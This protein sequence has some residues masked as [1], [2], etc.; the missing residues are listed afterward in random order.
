MLVSAHNELNAHVKQLGNIKFPSPIL[1]N[2]VLVYQDKT[3]QYVIWINSAAKHTTRDQS[4]RFLVD[5]AAVT[6]CL[7]IASLLMYV[8][9]MKISPVFNDDDD[10]DDYILL[11]LFL[12]FF[13]FYYSQKLIFWRIL[14][15]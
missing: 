15:N 8:R 7:N 10:E 3:Q 1:E 6:C 14:M 12:F 13:L 2:Y 4:R 9:R 11:L 5:T